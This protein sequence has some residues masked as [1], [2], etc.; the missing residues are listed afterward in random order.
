MP[1]VPS[2]NCLEPYPNPAF[3]ELFIDKPELNLTIEIYNLLGEQVLSQKCERTETT[4]NV[5]DYTP[6]NYFIKVTGQQYS[7][8]KRFEVM[9]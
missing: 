6:G 3:D 1:E 5:N 8:T 9:R 2:D 7:T 4:I